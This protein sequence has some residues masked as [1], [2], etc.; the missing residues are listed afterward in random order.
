MVR[1]LPL[2]GECSGLFPGFVMFDAYKFGVLSRRASWSQFLRSSWQLSLPELIRNLF[3]YRFYCLLTYTHNP[4]SFRQNKNYLSW[5]FDYKI[6]ERPISYLGKLFPQ[7][8]WRF[9]KL[10]NN[11]FYTWQFAHEI[12]WVP[13]ALIFFVNCWHNDDNLTHFSYVTFI[14]SCHVLKAYGM[15]TWHIMVKEKNNHVCIYIN[16]KTSWSFMR[17]PPFHVIL[18]VYWFAWE[19]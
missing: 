7:K 18:V 4:H 12:T 3:R 13:T 9:P 8:S 10:I 5:G 6:P 2:V 17:F 19:S 15:W 11:I 1:F 16:K 14:I